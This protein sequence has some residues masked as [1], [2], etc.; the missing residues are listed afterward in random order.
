M[1]DTITITIPDLD[2]NQALFCG[3]CFRWR[4]TEDDIFSGIIENLAVAVKQNGTDFTF[5]NCS[6]QDR[7]LIEKYFALDV[8]YNKVK[9]ILSRDQILKTAI[10]YA[11]GIRVLNQPF[12]ETL[13]SFIISQNNNIPRISGIIERL[14]ELAGEK[15]GDVFLFPTSA[16]LSSLSPEDLAPIRSG[17]RARYIIDAAQ[18]YESKSISIEVIKSASLDEARR[19]LMKITGV[20]PK[21]ANCTLLFGAKRYDAFPRDVWINRAMTALY[22]DGLPDFALPYAGI[23]QQYIFHYARTSG[24]L[25]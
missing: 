7:P 13:V 20:G 10:A 24:I 23:A 16:A 15:Q 4:K 22:P 21:V 12:F 1:G 5:L 2:L 3:Q 19:E 18:K 8:N 14:C 6:Q 17:F 9:D 25:K 11:R